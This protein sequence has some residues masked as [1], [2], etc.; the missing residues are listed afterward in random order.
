MNKLEK[1]MYD[2]LKDM[3]DSCKLS[4]IKL[5]FED[6][7]LNM[8]QA[9]IISSI[10]YKA[11]VDVS[12]KIGGAEAKRDI[13]DAKILWVHKVVAPMIESE[14]ALKKFTDAVWKIYSDDEKDN[15]E[16]MINIETI[17]G[18]NAA[19]SML[20]SDKAQNLS[21]VVLWRSDFVG[22]MWKE[23]SF[24]NSDIMLKTASELA[25]I[26]KQTN[27]K[28][29]VW[30][31]VNAE[32]IDFFKQLQ[33]IHLSGLETRNVI[34]KSDMLDLENVESAIAQALNFE[35][36]LLQVKDKIYET[37]INEDSHRID[38]IKSRFNKH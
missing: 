29:F 27:K 19:K 2:S 18:F 12:M 37:M 6:E 9:Q 28:F 21:W 13:R 5:S 26:C 3:K 31:N 1:S 30:G 16:F 35:L 25:D 17:T 20:T 4:W 7:W 10:A 34:F 33:K 8:D 36:L 15:T 23:K 14:Y 38:D 11:G 24:V 22:S 32:S